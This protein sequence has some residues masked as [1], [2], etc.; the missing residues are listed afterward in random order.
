MAYNRFSWLDVMFWIALI[1]L[2][3]WIVLKAFGFINTSMIVEV[4]PY[5]S[6]VFIAGA[7]WQQFRNMQGDILDIKRVVS[8]FLRIEH[9]HNLVM[10]GNLKHKR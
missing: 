6:A 2:V 9:E 10:E 1:A 4:I 3:I 5:L 7:I 8:R